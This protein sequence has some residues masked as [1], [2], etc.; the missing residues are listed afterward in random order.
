MP[1]LPAASTV[2]AMSRETDFDDPLPGLPPRNLALFLDVDGTLLDIAPIP[3]AVKVPDGLCSVLTSLFESLGGA[4]AIVSGRPIK[5]IDQLFKPLVLP[6]SGEHGF[7]IRRIPDKP[8]ERLQPSAALNLLRPGIREL[9]KQ[10]PGVIPNTN[11]ARS[12]CIS[13]R[14]R[15]RRSR[16]CVQSR[17]WSAR[18]RR[19]S[20]SSPARW[21]MRSN[22]AASTRAARL[23][24]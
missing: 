22:R 14:C 13:A 12:R 8:V 7:E 4:L 16:C 1:R 2:A 24:K 23:R 17:R 15:T 11:R 10:M 6:A 21:S 19:N 3:D 20:R 18:I 9:A 5:Q